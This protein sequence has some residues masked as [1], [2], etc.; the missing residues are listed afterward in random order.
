MM[1]NE[2]AK[3]KCIRLDGNQI[4]VNF[5]AKHSVDSQIVFGENVL[6]KHSV[7]FQIAILFV[8]H[9]DV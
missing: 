1:K 5:V 6:Q 7:D 4:H 9:I 8:A 2:C 3:D